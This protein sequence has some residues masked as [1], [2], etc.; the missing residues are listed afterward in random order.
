MAVRSIAVAIR[1]PRTCQLA[2]PWAVYQIRVVRPNS[3]LFSLFL[4]AGRSRFRHGH[5]GRNAAPGGTHEAFGYSK[6]KNGLVQTMTMPCYAPLVDSAP[7]GRSFQCTTEELTVTCGGE[8]WHRWQWL[9]TR[10]DS[11]I[12][13]HYNNIKARSAVAAARGHRWLSNVSWKSL[14]KLC[15]TL[16]LCLWLSSSE[17]FPAFPTSTRPNITSQHD[18]SRAVAGAHAVVC[19]QRSS[20]RRISLRLLHRQLRQLRQ[21]RCGR[22]WSAAVPLV[23]WGGGASCSSGRWVIKLCQE[24]VDEE[25]LYAKSWF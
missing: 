9:A 7:S 1:A 10:S 13:G 22:P 8:N 6:R 21:P 16:L 2:P 19:F 5:H 20:K 23:V 11:G 17:Q 25:L 12:W 18:W 14:I 15:P 24:E 3:V 4:G